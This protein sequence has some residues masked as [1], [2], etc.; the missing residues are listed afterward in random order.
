MS[1]H[2]EIVEL[3]AR[4]ELARV[5]DDY[6]LSSQKGTLFHLQAWGRALSQ[7]YSYQACGY[8]ALEGGQVRGVLPL[9]QV[10]LLPA[11]QALLSTPLAV[12][13]GVC[14]DSDD[15]GATLTEHAGALAR[16]RSV[17]YVEYRNQ[18]ALGSFPVKDLYYT[19]RKEIFADSEKNLAAIPRKQRRMVRQGEK[20]GLQSTVGGAELLDAF[21]AVY[22]HS[23][24]NLGTPV[25]PKAWFAALLKE[26]GSACKILAVTR[27]SETIAAVM[28]FFFRDEVLP[29]YGGALKSSFQYAANDFMYWNLVC[30]AGSHGSRVFDFGRSK[31]DTGPFEF[32]RHWGFEPTPLPYQYDLVTSRVI[33]DF[34][35]KNSSF[36]LPIMVW[37]RLPLPI[38]TWLGPKII[39]FFP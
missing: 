34:S 38:A 22:A 13:G 8:L 39:R 24:R 3:R 16:R 27:E 4:P 11:G 35:P 29:Y 23:I 6:V 15:I 18:R 17:K 9:F 32:K 28:S 26:Y 33:P 2:I 25:F 12:Y 30:Y 21:Y 31:K 14:A 36:S 5:W 1:H 20:H 37:K 19:F 10:R 7:C